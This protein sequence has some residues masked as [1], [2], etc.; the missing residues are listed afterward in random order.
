M[1]AIGILGPVG[2]DPNDRQR[3]RKDIGIIDSPLVLL[4]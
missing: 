2:V 3:L 1:A 4:V